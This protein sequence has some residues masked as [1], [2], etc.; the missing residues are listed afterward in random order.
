[1]EF[2]IFMIVMDLLIPFTMIGFGR[3]FLKSAP[4]D[5]NGVFGYRTTMSMKNK[6][7]WNFAHNYCGKIWFYCGLVM[8]PISIIV[9]ILVFG[10]TKDFIGTVGGILCFIQMIPLVG[11]ILPT[12]LALK[13]TFDKNRKRR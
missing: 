5:I 13:K 4:K 7:T 11:S 10:K 8:L 12:E 3:Y 2:S 6:D 9:M 1:M